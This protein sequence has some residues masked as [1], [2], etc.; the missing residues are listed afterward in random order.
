MI[1]PLQFVR[2]PI[3]V[4]PRTIIATFDTDKNGMLS[5]AEV[6]AARTLVDTDANGMISF[7]EWRTYVLANLPPAPPTVPPTP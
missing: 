3:L 6:R 4:P 5:E 1:S 7:T 2:F